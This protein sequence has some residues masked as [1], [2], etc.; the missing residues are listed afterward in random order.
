[1]GNAVL[2]VFFALEALFVIG[3][4]LLLAIALTT[5]KALTG[6]QNTAT[7]A[8]TLLISKGPLNGTGACVHDDWTN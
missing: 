3:G 8:N 1:M 5:N 6:P 2:Y 7:I 4:I